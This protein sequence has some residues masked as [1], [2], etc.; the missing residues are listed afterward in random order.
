L[1]IVV[2]ALVGGWA[3]TLWAQGSDLTL[4]EKKLAQ[5]GR[6]ILTHDSLA[7]KKELNQ[8]FMTLLR[9]TLSRPESFDYPFDSLK[10]VSIIRPKDN[11]FRIFTWT[12]VDKDTLV[13]SKE[14]Y[15]YYGMIQR[16]FD[17]PKG[18]P[19][20]ITV[21]PLIQRVEI[22]KIPRFDALI[23]PHTEWYGA[24]YYHPRNS[25]YGVLTFDGKYQSRPLG[26]INTKIRYYVIL[27]WNGFKRGIDYKIADVIAF[28]AVDSNKVYF[29]V[30]IFYAK[31]GM[32]CRLVYQYSQNSPFNLNWGQIVADNGKKKYVLVLDHLEEG[33]KTGPR[34]VDGSYDAWEYVN[35]VY[36]LRKGY[37]TPYRNVRVYEPSLEKY[38]PNEL[39]LKALNE[40]TRVYEMGVDLNR[41]SKYRRS[42]VEELIQTDDDHLPPPR[43][44]I[45]GPDPQLLHKNKRKKK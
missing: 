19:P 24:I 4:V 21:I 41:P 20:K 18:T 40:K 35:K 17:G 12:M 6:E 5:I 2:F 9:Q 11:T 7:Y 28:D 25:E 34:G 31:N 10:T 23:V 38:D 44:K 16:K 45:D 42:R 43:P 14:N 1:A 33:K 26:R 8:K 27:G 36:E 30:P 13:N 37:F 22:N 29:G 32:K 39:R 15:S 3:Q